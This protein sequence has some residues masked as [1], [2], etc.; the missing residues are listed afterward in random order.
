MFLYAYKTCKRI[1]IPTIK[2]TKIRNNSVTKYSIYLSYKIIHYPQP[3][4][5]PRKSTKNRAPKQYKTLAATP[6]TRLKQYR[7]LEPPHS[8][9]KKKKKKAKKGERREC[10][11]RCGFQTVVAARAE[12]RHAA[13]VRERPYIRAG[14]LHAPRVVSH[15]HGI[16]CRLWGVYEQEEG[17][18][19][20]GYIASEKPNLRRRK[21]M[22]AWIFFPEQ[23]ERNSLTMH[24]V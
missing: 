3:A 2:L 13:R 23:V 14:R 8:V 9:K 21:S 12:I 15:F 10:S 5:I 17:E 22:C 16:S 24:L 11:R 20:A 7:T 6:L 1:T 18:R 19:I 4:N